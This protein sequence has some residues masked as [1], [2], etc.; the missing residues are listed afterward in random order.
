MIIH[1]AKNSGLALTFNHVTWK[2]VGKHLLFR[3]NPYTKS[4]EVKYFE[5]TTHC[6]KNIGL[7]LTFDRVTWKSKW[8]F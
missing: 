1:W 3:G 6:V 2:S 7:T 5:Q 4:E 8:I